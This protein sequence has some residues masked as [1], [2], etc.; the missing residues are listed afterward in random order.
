MEKKNLN[1]SMDTD[2]VHNTMDHTALEADT[3]LTDETQKDK[4]KGA[5]QSKY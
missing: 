1:E 4:D 3:H 5:V 2:E